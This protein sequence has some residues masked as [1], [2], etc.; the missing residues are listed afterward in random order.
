LKN[1]KNYGQ[2]LILALIL[3]FPRPNSYHQIQRLAGPISHL[4]SRDAYLGTASRKSTIQHGLHFSNSALWFC[5]LH[6]DF[7]ILKLNKG[8]FE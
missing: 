2:P 5:F 1:L 7:C 3:L 4:V 8:Q 6:F